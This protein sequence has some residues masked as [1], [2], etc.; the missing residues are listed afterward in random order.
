M[1]LSYCHVRA[2]RGKE[3]AHVAVSFEELPAC[4]CGDRVPGECVDESGRT[5]GWKGLVGC[6]AVNAGGWLG[7]LHMYGDTGVRGGGGHT[8][9]ASSLS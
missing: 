1:Q 7:I 6:G 3:L 2:V 4:V 5:E 8:A 9:W